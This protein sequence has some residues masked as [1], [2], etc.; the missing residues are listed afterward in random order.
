MAGNFADCPVGQVSGAMSSKGAET[1]R[2]LTMLL[3]YL[4][5]YATV[6]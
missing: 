5:Y 6:L 3:Q 4:L 1:T 2:L